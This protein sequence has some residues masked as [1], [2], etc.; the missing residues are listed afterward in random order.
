MTRSVGAP[1]DG[2][3]LL[4]VLAKWKA[5]LAIGL[6]RAYSAPVT[7]R[8]YWPSGVVT[9][10]AG[11]RV[12]RVHRLTADMQPRSDRATGPATWSEARNHRRLRLPP[13]SGPGEGRPRRSVKIF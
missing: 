8:S 12:G 5:G 13:S 9:L 4:L 3:R 10:M 2:P 1:S 11:G 7:T 6:S